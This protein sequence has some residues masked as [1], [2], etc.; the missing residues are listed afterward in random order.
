MRVKK[1]VI[2][3]DDSYS[4]NCEEHFDLIPKLCKAIAEGSPAE[5][6]DGTASATSS[7]N[8]ETFHTFS[9]NNNTLNITSQFFPEGDCYLCPDEDCEAFICHYEDLDENGILVCEECGKEY[10]I[11]QLKGTLP[12]IDKKSFKI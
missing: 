3:V 4:V 9:F 2:I 11:G 8:E 6:F 7:Y 12:R 5:S 10:T 1:N